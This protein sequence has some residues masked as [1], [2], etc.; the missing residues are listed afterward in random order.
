MRLGWL[1]GPRHWWLRA[2]R[3]RPAT[4][5]SLRVR[6]LER[7]RVLDAALPGLTVAPTVI[8][9]VAT[10]T[11]TEASPL[12][13]DWAATQANAST[14]PTAAPSQATSN[15]SARHQA[16][17]AAASNESHDSPALTANLLASAQFAANASAPTTNIPPVLVVQ[18]D[19][20]VDEGL[21]LDLR[22]IDGAPPL[23]LFVDPNLL[24]SHTATV[25]WG[26]G[27]ATQ[28]VVIFAGAGTGVLS[29]SHTY[30][31]DGVYTV[32]VSVFDSA[33]GSDTKSFSVLVNNVRPRL[34][35]SG[36]TNVNEG[37][38]ASWTIGPVID[39]GDDTVSQYIVHWG[40]GETNTFSSAELNALGRIV[41]HRYAD[42]PNNY[43]IVV[44]VID[45][46][47]TH[48][49]AGTHRVTVRNVPPV[50]VVQ[51]DQT[52]N[53]G[54]T[55]NLSGIDG[56]PLGLF[57]D[58]GIF[59]MHTVVVD[60]GDGT[61]EPANKL[62]SGIA[63]T[64]GGTHRY[65]DDG[66]YQVTVTVTDKDGASDTKSFLVTVLNVAPQV[67]ITGPDTINEGSFGTWTIG[68]VIDPGDD[69]VTQYIVRWGDGTTST[70]S[71]AAL[72]EA[73]RRISHYYADGLE[74]HTIAIDL[75]DEDGT[76]LAAGTFRVH[77]TNLPPAF[78]PVDDEPFEGTDISASGF[79][80]IRISFTD[81]GY[82]NPNNVGDPTNR[83]EFG[84]VAETFTIVIHWGD[85]MVTTVPV[86]QV[87]PGSRVPVTSVDQRTGQVIQDA[88]IL[89]SSRVSGFEGSPT[90]G[91][92]VIEHRFNQ[93]NLAS[94][95]FPPDPT[96]VTIQV[97][98]QDD[99]G[100]QTSGSI[101]VRNPL[102][103]GELP[104]LIAA[105]A[106]GPAEFVAPPPITVVP[107]EP[108]PV[109]QAL[110]SPEIRVVSGFVG[111]TSERY[112]VLVVISP[113]G[114]ELENY[115]LSDDALLDLRRLFARLPDGHYKI[116]QVHTDTNLRRL[117]IDVY[118]RGGRV[119]DPADDSE[120]TRDR[121]P[122][123]ESDSDNQPIP[124]TQHPTNQNVPDQAEGTPQSTNGKSPVHEQ[125]VVAP[126]YAP[127]LA[128]HGDEWKP[129]LPGGSTSAHA[130]RRTA[131]LAALAVAAA[132]GS[133]SQR[134]EAVLRQADAH[135]WRRLR[136]AGRLPQSTATRHSLSLPHGGN[137]QKTN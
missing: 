64:L 127:D 129:V 131:P 78:V 33:G 92:M 35:I 90:T 76:H 20:T 24:D 132:D 80:V 112:F 7:R 22:G 94:P 103:R 81:P 12:E 108:P 25:N 101:Q 121:P 51:V 9:D 104:V 100:G 65:A 118:V 52:I 44:D 11:A 17:S 36:P 72:Q 18:V 137:R 10:S 34:A 13:F 120:G 114:Q 21:L 135:A 28:P 97:T 86:T 5:A 41:S 89:E 111:I 1:I 105:N 19:Q 75:V 123:G 130:L 119:I 48:P 136:R 56:P 31:D 16:S 95:P 29:A 77:V 53:E 62:T 14:T 37:T 125:S 39:P 61:I 63:V 23:G 4:T 66:L 116:F 42:G 68:P 102:L 54:E 2:R 85:R 43:T 47:G 70:Y 110:Q 126:K 106:R 45:E 59:D 109:L 96:R 8:V 83:G 98:V 15:E 73:N 57:V 38:L 67:N 50:L 55:L 46:D 128:P 79:N 27:S 107:A 71:A 32:T 69:T 134:L 115:L 88:W 49:G 40:D 26:D 122:T 91:W 133:W 3:H 82:D 124:P 117:V 74:A 113:D 99:D 84:E 30:A 93:T 87:A 58:P 60:W 6:R